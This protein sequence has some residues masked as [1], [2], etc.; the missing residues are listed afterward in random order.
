MKI[1][2]I[3]RR[4]FA[5]AGVGILVASVLTLTMGA[6][7]I[8]PDKPFPKAF[9]AYV[10]PARQAVHDHLDGIRFVHLRL[11]DVRCREDGGFALL[12]DQIEAPYLQTRY[13]VAMTGAQ[14]PTGWS[15]GVS[16]TER[17][18]PELLYFLGDR[19]VS[20]TG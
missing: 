20:C 9:A 15:V 3:P 2:S 4:W 5:L 11:A 10:E 16:L 7:L 13:A 8:W 18:D 12:F 1:L 17:E 6:S 19:E 14:A